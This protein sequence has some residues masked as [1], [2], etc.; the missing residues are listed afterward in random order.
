MEYEKS[1]IQ[2]LNTS[3]IITSG[4]A[5]DDKQLEQLMNS[6]QTSGLLQPILVQEAPTDGYYE[7]VTG[8]LRL[9]ACKRLGWKKISVIIR[10][11]RIA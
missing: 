4:R 3:Q 5:I 8:E 9:E 10:D 2:E 1:H 6:I 7:V 11:R